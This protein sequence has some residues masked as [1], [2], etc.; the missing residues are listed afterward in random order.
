MSNAQLLEDLGKKPI[1]L[2]TRGIF[3]SDAHGRIGITSGLSE[4][5]FVYDRLTGKKITGWS[6]E[7]DAILL[8]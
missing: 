6:R 7:G 4:P 5:I 1:I 8:N 2:N 3:E